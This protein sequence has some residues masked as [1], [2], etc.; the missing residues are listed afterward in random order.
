VN[1][2]KLERLCFP[3]AAFVQERTGWPVPRVYPGIG[4]GY[5]SSNRRRT[6]G[7]PTTTSSNK[8]SSSPTDA[9][10][11]AS[12]FDRAATPASAFACASRPIAWHG[13]HVT[14]YVDHR[15][16]ETDEFRTRFWQQVKKL[17]DTARVLRAGICCRYLDRGI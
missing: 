10:S 9:V 3:A 16:F 8:A 4:S 5:Q 11:V 12:A 2:K 6:T 13:G 17:D 15:Y 7:V 14:P 1:A